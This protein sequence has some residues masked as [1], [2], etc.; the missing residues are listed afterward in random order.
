MAMKEAWRMTDA[1]GRERAHGERAH[2]EFAVRRVDIQ[3]GAGEDTLPEHKLAV[4]RDA[5]AKVKLDTSYGNVAATPNVKS[6]AT[7]VF[8]GEGGEAKLS[9]AKAL[10]LETGQALFRVDVGQVV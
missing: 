10:A 3:A 2:G 7:V 4:L 5:I 9:A 8:S 6:G 1:L